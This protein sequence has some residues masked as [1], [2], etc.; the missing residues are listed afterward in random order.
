MPFW[1]LTLT[2]L[3]LRPFT[4]EPRLEPYPL[5]ALPFLLKD[6]YQ[7]DLRFLETD[8]EIP[9]GDPRGLNEFTLA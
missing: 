4:G 2:P 3:D 6:V 7:A 1:W 8:G 9:R 5:K